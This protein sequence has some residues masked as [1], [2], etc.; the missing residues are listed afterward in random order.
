MPELQ[1]ISAAA[2]QE[3]VRE[4]IAKASARQVVP[5][6]SVQERERT[7]RTARANVRVE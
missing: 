3:A 2:Q 4:R 1:A 5:H 7:G 6:P